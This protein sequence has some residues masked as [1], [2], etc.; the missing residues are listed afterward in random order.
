[1]K[2]FRCGKENPEGSHFCS[3]CGTEVSDPSGA[4][5]AV[6]TEVRQLPHDL[7][8]V[9]RR[10]L[11]DD[12]E[13]HKELGRGGMAVVYGATELALGRTV[14]I[15]VLPPDLAQSETMERFKREA[16]MAAQLDHANIIPVYRVG[17]AGSML[18]IA[19]KYVEGRALDEIITAQG[20]L[21][22]PVVLAVVRATA[23]A[24]SF[25]HSRSIIHRDIKGANILVERDG[26]ILVTDFGIARA[27]EDKTLTATGAVIGTPHFMSP[28]QCAGERLGPQSDQYS[29]G[30]LTFQMLTG[31]VPFDADSVIGIMQHHFFTPV[32]DVRAVR[33]DVPE[34]LISVLNRMM[35]KQAEERYEATDDLL[36][37]LE[38]IPFSEADRKVSREQLRRVA[39][40]EAL[41][42]VRTGSLPPLP[43]TRTRAAMLES[44]T[45][46]AVTKP[47]RRRRSFAIALA[48]IAIVAG[49]AVVYMN[50]PREAPWTSASPETTQESL[51][52]PGS[53]PATQVPSES[54]RAPAAKT[55]SR[56][57]D[58]A[59]SVRST[60]A[61][62]PGVTQHEQ[63][64]PTAEAAHEAP[65]EPGG[66]GRLR[67][68]T[69]PPSAVIY[70]DEDSVGVGFVFDLVVPAGTRRI[71]V[72][73]AGYATFD[74]TI[75]VDPS[76]TVT[77]T[78]IILRSQGGPS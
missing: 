51:A 54:P 6:S 41:P 72:V 68:R 5:V 71:R 77:L 62:S 21:T 61:T 28:E 42:M 76:A 27:V 78:N 45:D 56:Q 14:A 31:E 50:L 44:T 37:A 38:G 75:V 36:A 73:S 57:I 64:R 13:V 74:S 3:G 10:H 65:T 7:L 40:G 66:E 70:V 34:A 15:K 16:R 59:E 43:A 48:A 4:I 30:V 60:S 32:P 47:Q 52:A 55:P 39:H 18:Y 22:V 35:A 12:Y 24:L 49:A 2:C 53:Q 19:M 58:T 46:A 67:I 25:A 33:K 29:L 8:E 63:P 23:A 20:A 26:R 9:L 11:A 1:M 69:T 17:Q